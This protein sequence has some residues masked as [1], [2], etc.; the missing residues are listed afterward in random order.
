MSFGDDVEI[1][2]REVLQNSLDARCPGDEPV[3]V[4]FRLSALAGE[5]RDAF[6]ASAG[7]PE[8]RRH[9]EAGARLL[10]SL[11]THAAR[12][13]NPGEPLPVLTI[14]DEN[15]LGLSGPERGSEGRFANFARNKLFSDK[16]S[17]A[18]GGSY[19]LGK[20]V[21][22]AFSGLHTIYFHS[23]PHGAERPRFLGVSQLPYH[24]LDGDH[25]FDGPGWFGIPQADGWAASDRAPD[26]T[27]L[28]A[29]G[30]ARGDPPGTTIAI[31]DF[32]PS[33]MSSHG[34]LSPFPAERTPATRPM[35]RSVA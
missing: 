20:S 23:V 12:V 27:R 14:A 10:P 19:G 26:P 25:C 17:D 3:T 28:A 34:Q 24:E 30:L 21:L 8:L 18:A 9:A 33:A 6:L 13:S 1:F 11:G 35:S 29:L 31:P 7:W 15:A 2:V 16:E 32:R 4:T 5:D 22:W